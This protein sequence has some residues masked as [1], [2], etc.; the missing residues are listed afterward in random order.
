M[1]EMNGLDLMIMCGKAKRE[2]QETNKDFNDDDYY[3]IFGL[4][5]GRTLCRETGIKIKDE[6]KGQKL[7][8]MFGVDVMYS[9][10]VEKDKA[11][12]MRKVDYDIRNDL[13]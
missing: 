11:Y 12:I 2:I 1:A 8:K 3:Y 13:K 7:C 10:L 9:P 5:A 4:D 6:R